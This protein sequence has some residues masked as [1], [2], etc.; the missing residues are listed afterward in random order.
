MHIITHTHNCLSQSSNRQTLGH[1]LIFIAV[2]V[3]AKAYMARKSAD[4]LRRSYFYVPSFSYFI[5]PNNKQSIFY[6]LN[7]YQSIPG[8]SDLQIFLEPWRTSICSTH[9]YLHKRS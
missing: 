4:K 7:W 1:S 5:L 2:F 6:Y 3:I 8:V 9:T